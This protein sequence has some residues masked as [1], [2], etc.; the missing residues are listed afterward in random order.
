[1]WQLS[2]KAQQAGATTKVMALQDGSVVVA[3]ARDRGVPLMELSRAAAQAGLVVSVGSEQ[4]DVAL[5]ANPDAVWIDFVGERWPERD[6]E[7]G[8]GG[9]DASIGK[10]TLCHYLTAP[11]YDVREAV[12]GAEEVEVAIGR[13]AE[14]AMRAGAMDPRAVFDIR[15]KVSYV[16][17]HPPSSS[18]G[19]ASAMARG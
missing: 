3:D 5:F 10:G 4:R 1:M 6:R 13:A 9:C 7:G 8:T 2:G 15:T 17:P 16:S 19:C 18:A 12:G 11:I 14:I